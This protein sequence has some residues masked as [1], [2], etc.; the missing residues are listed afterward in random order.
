[1]ELVKCDLGKNQEL[2]DLATKTKELGVTVAIHLAGS[3]DI[4]GSYEELHAKNVM[5]PIKLYALLAKAGVERFVHGSTTAVQGIFRQEPMV[6][7]A[8]TG[9]IPRSPYV[10]SKIIAELELARLHAHMNITQTTSISRLAFAQYAFVMGGNQP[11]YY[12]FM[13]G[14]KA[15]KIPILG[16]GENIR[17]LVHW[18][19]AGRITA[20]IALRAE[21]PDLQRFIIAYPINYTQEEMTGMFCQAL[22]VPSPRKHIPYLAALAFGPIFAGTPRELIKAQAGHTPLPENPTLEMAIFRML[23][24]DPDTMLDPQIGINKM[25]EAY[26]RRENP[27][28]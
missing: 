11:A 28:A 13:E 10:R 21:L 20:L 5:V 27:T 24:V 12:G 15:G 8:P 7:A 25:V 26:K 23:R 17:P 9:K 4:T 2:V 6:E 1:M 22:E 19:D 18:D 16:K 3:T 14:L